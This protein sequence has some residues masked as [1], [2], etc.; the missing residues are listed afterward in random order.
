MVRKIDLGDVARNDC[1]GAK[2][3]TGQE[4]L[5]LFGPGILS[6]I[7]DDKG[8]IKCSPP[9]EGQGSNLD[10]ILFHEPGGSIEI[11]HVM[12]G[13]IE[14]TEVRVYFFSDIARQEIQVFRPLP[15][16]AGSGQSF[17]LPVS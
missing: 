13:I 3:Q 15:Q 7:E 6:L 14:G 9:H 1:L 12:E 5:H 4:H 17:R 16:Q 8:V 10:H 2:A 11:H